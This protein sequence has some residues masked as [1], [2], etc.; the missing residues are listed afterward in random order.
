[1]NASACP[2][3]H[4]PLNGPATD[5][6]CPRCAG[7]LLLD[8]ELVNDAEV[9]SASPSGLRLGDY[10]LGA[11]LGRGAMGVVYRARQ[12]RLKRDV[13]VKV[14]LASRFVGEAARKRFLVEAEFAAQLDHPNIVPIHEVGETEDGPFYAM[15]LIEDGT[16]AERVSN[17]QFQISDPLAVAGLV[18]KIARAVHHAHQR[19]ILHRDLKPGNILLDAQGEPH[20]ADFGLARQLGADSS[21]TVTGSSLGTPAYM[22]PEQVRGDKSITTASDVWSLGAILYH[23]LAGR[24]PF[25]GATSMEVMRKVMESDPAPPSK[26]EVRGEKGEVVRRLS[27]LTSY[28]SPDLETICLKCLEKDPAHRF[29]SALALAEDL[30]RWLKHEPIRARPSTPG[31]RLV[32]W[33]RRRPAIA[34]LTVL[35]ALLFL[36]GAAGVTWQWRRAN[37]HANAAVAALARSRDAL[38]QANY[39]RAHALRTSHSLGQRIESLKALREAAAIRPSP[40]LREE[41]I[42]TMAL[43]D[44]EDAGSWLAIPANTMETSLDGNLERIALLQPAGGVEIRRF[45]AGQLLLTLTNDLPL[46]RISFAA[47]GDHLLTRDLLRYRVW[48]ARSGALVFE[49]PVGH[50]PKADKITATFSLDGRW[51]AYATSDS[52]VAWRTLDGSSEAGR[53]G[54]LSRI[55]SMVFSAEAEFLAIRAGKEVQVWR[56]SDQKRVG[57]LALPKSS[58]NFQW[59]RREQILAVGCEDKAVYVWDVLSDQVQTLTGHRREGVQV[60]FH[61]DSGLLA[62]KSFDQVLR[63]WDSIARLPLLETTFATPGDFSANGQWLSARSARGLGRLRVHQPE[64]ARLFHPPMGMKA[65]RTQ[66]SSDGQFLAG[67]D[68]LSRLVLWETVSGQRLAELKLSNLKSVQFHGG[69][70]LTA[71]REGITSWTNARP[72]DGW[73]PVKETIAVRVDAPEAFMVGS[74]G[75][76]VLVARREGMGQIYDFSSGRLELELRGQ[77]NFGNAAFSADGQWI[78]SGYWDNGG[79]HSSE[80][81]IW[82]ATNGRPVRKIPMGNCAASFSGDGRWMLIAAA[83]RYLQY[84]VHGHPTN[85]PLV[86]RF[87]CESTGFVTSSAA[88]SGD[89]ALLAVLTNSTIVRLIEAATGRELARF[90]PWPEGNRVLSLHF[91]HAGRWLVADTDFGPFVWDLA[92]VRARLREMNLDWDGPPDLPASRPSG[93]TDRRAPHQRPAS[94]GRAFPARSPEATPAQLDLEPHF[95]ALLTENWLGSLSRDNSL[96]SLP[97][98]I[99]TLDEVTW[100]IR[101]IVQLSS[102]SLRRTNPRYP[103]AVEGIQVGQ[104]CRRLHFLTA[105]GFSEKGTGTEV[106]HYVIHYADGQERRVPVRVAAEIGDYWLDPKKSPPVRQARVAWTGQNEHARSFGCSLQLLH[107]AWE[108]PR[109]TVAI[110]SLDFVSAMN[111]PAPFLLAITVEE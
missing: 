95:N 84:A 104:S 24:P 56:L 72:S 37:H 45:P 93:V 30:E 39:D 26:C 55:E 40:E 110:T 61:P 102:A 46:R 9:P 66:I 43:T 13:A 91:D 109:P 17:P 74:D 85:W 33:A 96:G 12:P 20:I 98:G 52:E 22:S 35:A 50:E 21:L 67:H 41:A 77:N 31:E 92:L 10:E 111:T 82:S 47:S 89:G 27:P 83:G 94:P 59:H 97:R 105:F 14:I 44:L 4:G 28:F 68:G 90:T 107:W 80:F 53:V 11:E 58:L 69:R 25:E 1:M 51:L 73:Q 86:R 71:S 49:R 62:S 64:E 65:T 87:E 88:F 99:Q 38:W 100:D 34:A 60:Y 18:A 36:A 23:L 63:L 19:G 78:A 16:L 2:R 57:T 8:T 15:K 103:S 106:G 79:K 32:K 75:S 42:A 3:C 29:A 108:N 5:R 70:L 6:Y 76:R 54:G 7:R 48:N 81:W 101:A